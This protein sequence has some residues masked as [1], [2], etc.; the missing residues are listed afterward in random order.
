M[1][2]GAPRRGP[3]PLLAV[4]GALL[5]LV[6]AAA[7]A[8]HNMSRRNIPVDAVIAD[9]NG[10]L[11]PLLLNKR[12]LRDARTPPLSPL[13]YFAYDAKAKT[14]SGNYGQVFSAALKGTGDPPRSFA[15]KLQNGAN[16]WQTEAAALSDLSMG[17]FFPHFWGSWEPH[18][19][20]KKDPMKQ[21]YGIAMTLA[22]SD[23]EREIAQNHKA[24]QLFSSAS[25]YQYRDEKASQRNS[26]YMGV[27]E[28]HAKHWIAEL[29]LAIGYLHEKGYVH[30]DIKP[31][32]V[33]IDADGHLMLADFGNVI[34]SAEITANWKQQPVGGDITVAAPEWWTRD[35]TAKARPN[36]APYGRGVDWWA[37]GVVAYRLFAG[38]QGFVSNV[39]K[40]NLG[41]FYKKEFRNM[42]VLTKHLK[43]AAQD[44]RKLEAD[45][46][47]NPAAFKLMPREAASF[48]KALLHPDPNARL[49]RYSRD[50][51]KVQGWRAVLSHPFL[52]GLSFKK[53]LENAYKSVRS[54]NDAIAWAANGKPPADPRK[55]KA[56]GS[57]VEYEHVDCNQSGVPTESEEKA[58]LRLEREDSVSHNQ[59]DDDD[60]DDEEEQEEKPKVERKKKIVPNTA[61][62]K[63]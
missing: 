53:F 12:V 32:N 25:P 26:K 39:N 48:I 36:T 47:L 54:H 6:A 33:L 55:V 60:D 44:G 29:A 49:G 61:Y 28:H 9:P 40:F 59:G 34:K 4:A 56:D 8:P 11:K 43:K 58:C 10:P 21:M 38:E 62:A 51:T 23:L 50:K 3:A 19:T 42:D 24:S 16:G 27:D 31:G 2:A 46:L 18:K 13:D 35:G 30:R 41:S 17:P 57:A 20:D 63:R 14:G 37:L 15:I 45:E 5:L 22:T 52:S 1:A 7:A